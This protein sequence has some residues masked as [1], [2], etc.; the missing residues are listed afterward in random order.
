[1]LAVRQLTS[2]VRGAWRLAGRMAA[3]I[4]SAVKRPRSPATVRVMA[5]DRAAGPPVSKCKPWEEASKMI[6]SPWSTHTR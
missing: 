2:A 1:M 5:P 6:S 4:C 3:T